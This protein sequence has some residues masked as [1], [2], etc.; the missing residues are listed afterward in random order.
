[1]NRS[2]SVNTIS[3][4]HTGSATLMGDLLKSQG[5]GKTAAKSEE[6]KKLLNNLNKKPEQEA[7]PYAATSVY[8]EQGYL[9]LTGKT[10]KEKDAGTKEKP[11]YNYKDVSNRIR[12]AKTSLSAGQAVIAAKRKVAEIKRKIAGGKEE[13]E[14]LQLALTHAR[15]VE[16]AARKKKHHLELEEMVE[17]VR[18]REDGA[19]NTDGENARSTVVNSEIEKTQEEAAGKEDAIFEERE[20]LAGEFFGEPEGKSVALSP[21]QMTDTVSE[22]MMEELNTMIAEFGEEELQALE[23]ELERLEDLEVFDPHMSEEDLA[24]WKL[25]HRNAE[26]KALLKADMDYLKGMIKHTLAKAGGGAAGV[27]TGNGSG[28]LGL[29]GIGAG[30]QGQTFAVDISVGTDTVVS[31]AAEPAVDV[32][33]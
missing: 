7:N 17:A 9:D 21:E 12:R 4:Y 28:S 23:E 25:K 31:A 8:K 30:M 22:E 11:H 26:N 33:I 6:M 5:S 3:N 2:M 14:E 16:M 29:T 19:E 15:R 18:K 10:E 13:P 20:Q 24:E 27:G 32:Q 1:M